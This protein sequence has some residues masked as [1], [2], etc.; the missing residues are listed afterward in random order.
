MIPKSITERP[1]AEKSAAVKE[2]WGWISA[3]L[4]GDAAIVSKPVPSAPD[5]LALFSIRSAISVSVTFRPP[6]AAD[7]SFF[8]ISSII[9]SVIFAAFLII[10]NSVF[11]FTAL[12]P[13]ITESIPLR[14]HRNSVSGSFSLSI[15]TSGHVN[16]EETSI[17]GLSNPRETA[18]A[19]SSF[20]TAAAAFV[21]SLSKSVYGII[22]LHCAYL[23]ARFTS[24]GRSI[25]FPLPKIKRRAS[26]GCPVR[27]L[28]E[29]F[30]LP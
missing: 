23:A 22:L 17:L 16:E 1:G 28:N 25:V 30:L 14:L 15:S 19:D 20:S 5:L 9:L 3:L 10:L 4:A 12:W 8:S 18:S 21:K 29:E 13:D 7:R 26:P 24:H 27:Y 6:P 11:S 2:G